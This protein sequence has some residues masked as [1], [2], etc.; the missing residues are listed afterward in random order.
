MTS[1]LQRVPLPRS[2]YKSDSFSYYLS[3]YAILSMHIHMEIKESSMAWLVPCCKRGSTIGAKV[4]RYLLPLCFASRL[5][6][7][8]LFTAPRCYNSTHRYLRQEDSPLV[9]DLPTR[10]DASL[11]HRNRPACSKARLSLGSSGYSVRAC[12]HEPRSYSR[13]PIGPRG[14][15]SVSDWAGTESISAHPRVCASTTIIVSLVACIV[16]AALSKMVDSSVYVCP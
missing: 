7:S 3:R 5:P 4:A 8:S 14:A 11:A 9:V 16:G 12:V 1:S 10:S 2:T 6:L 13:S 15:S